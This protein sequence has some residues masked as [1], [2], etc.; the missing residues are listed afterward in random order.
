MGI[1]G[2]VSKHPDLELD[3]IGPTDLAGSLIRRVMS[4]CWSDTSGNV[5]MLV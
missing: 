4:Q 5:S 3:Y 2:I 1:L